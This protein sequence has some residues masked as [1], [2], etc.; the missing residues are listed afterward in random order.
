[1]EVAFNLLVSEVLAG[2]ASSTLYAIYLVRFRCIPLCSAWRSKLTDLL[3]RFS[4]RTINIHACPT[5]LSSEEVSNGKKNCFRQT[6][7]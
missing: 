3:Q 4:L 6:K 5:L 1:M 7:T 2:A